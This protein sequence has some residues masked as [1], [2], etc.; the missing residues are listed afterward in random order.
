MKLRTVIEQPSVTLELANGMT[1]TVYDAG[2]WNSS[3]TITVRQRQRDLLQG[4]PSAPDVP[5]YDMGGEYEFTLPDAW[6]IGQRCSA[7]GAD[8]GA[9]DFPASG[10]ATINVEHRH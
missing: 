8:P 1:I 4:A 2:E 3:P 6:E 5:R 9:A 7:Y 10:H